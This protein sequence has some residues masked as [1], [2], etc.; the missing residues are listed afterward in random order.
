MTTS[1]TSSYHFL[2]LFWNQFCQV[3]VTLA[4]LYH[5]YIYVYNIYIYIYTLDVQQP[6][7]IGWR[8]RT[9]IILVG[10]YL[11]PKGTT[12]F[13]MV[14]DFQGSFNRQ[15]GLP[16]L[17]VWAPWC[18]WG[19]LYGFLGIITL[20]TQYTV[21]FLRISHRGPRWDRGTSNYPLMALEKMSCHTLFPSTIYWPLETAIFPLDYKLLSKPT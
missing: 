6:S 9:T 1:A 2:N 8:Y 15:F 17:T 16:L 7:F 18:L 12:I 14:V 3:G 5:I 13:E 4:S 21:R 20:K 19:V 11:L 10:V